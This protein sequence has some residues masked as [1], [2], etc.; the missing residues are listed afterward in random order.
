MN[1]PSKYHHR[2]F[3]TK[4]TTFLELSISGGTILI[5]RLCLAPKFKTL[6]QSLCCASPL[7]LGC[8]HRGVDCYGCGKNRPGGFCFYHCIIL[9]EVDGNYF[10]AFHW[11]EGECHCYAPRRKKRKN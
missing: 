9:R 1:F 11:A 8:N 7:A 2:K 6:H 5:Y 10:T 3:S 4:F